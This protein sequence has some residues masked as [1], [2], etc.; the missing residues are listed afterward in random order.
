MTAEEEQAMTTEG[1]QAMTTAHG[2]LV[3]QSQGGRMPPASLLLRMTLNATRPQ[4]CADT[5]SVGIVT[6][7]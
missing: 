4:P 5:P 2:P 1:E 7:P 3:G 6:S